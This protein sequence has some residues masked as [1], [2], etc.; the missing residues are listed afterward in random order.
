MPCQYG[1]ETSIVHEVGYK[2]VVG[3]RYEV[4]TS[5]G[6]LPPAKTCLPTVKYFVSKA[7]KL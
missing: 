4:C 6:A 1:V 7:H 3:R 5:V 2:T